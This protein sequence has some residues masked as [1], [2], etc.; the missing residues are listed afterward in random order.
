[1][2]V[3]LAEIDAPEIDQP[4]GVEAQRIVCA[5]ICGRDVE[6]EERGTSYDRIVGLIRVQ[7]SDTSEAMVRA[8]AAWDYDQYDSNPAMPGL[9]ATARRQGKGLWA[10]PAPIAPW[11][12]R[13]GRVGW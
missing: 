3:R 11:D 9:E 4:Y 1:M 6:V 2:K 13:H 5:M 12:W 7:G 8:G 10:T